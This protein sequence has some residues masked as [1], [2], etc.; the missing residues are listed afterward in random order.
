MD[1][2]E[3]VGTGAVPV[4]TDVYNNENFSQSQLQ[5][6]YPWNY[7]YVLSRGGEEGR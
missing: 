5:L 1:Q 3:G 4:G 6:N 7:K 2:K